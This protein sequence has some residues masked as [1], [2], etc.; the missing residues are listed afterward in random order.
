MIYGTTNTHAVRDVTDLIG[1]RTLILRQYWQATA[2]NPS[3]SELD[4][5]KPGVPGVSGGLMLMGE[6]TMK[7][8][9]RYATLWTFQGVNGDGKSPTFKTRGNSIDY[10]FEPGFSQV[11]IQVHK[12]FTAMLAKFQGYP[13]NDGTTVIWPPE[14]AASGGS[15]LS[16]K[17]QTA[18]TTNPMYGIQAFFEMDGVYRYRYAATSL[19]GNLEDGVGFIATNLP[20]KPPALKDGRN[21]LKAPTAYERKGYIYDIMEYYWLSRRG[22]WPLPVYQRGYFGGSGTGGIPNSSFGTTDQTTI[23]GYANNTTL[24]EQRVMT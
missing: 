8:R 15:G 17:N 11:P 23:D 10:G 6:Q 1:I 21:W 19:P 22:G 3:Q 2:T 5:M 4:G 20:G 16:T 18:G 12:D 13:G 9:G 7:E 14:L 24:T